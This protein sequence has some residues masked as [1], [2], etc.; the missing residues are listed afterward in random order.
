MRSA[1]L[2]GEPS[3]NSEDPRA[4]TA[5]TLGSSARPRSCPGDRATSPTITDRLFSP[6][7]R[8]ALLL[9]AGQLEREMVG[10]AL[11]ADGVEVPP[12]PLPALCRLPAPSEVHGQGGVLEGRQGRPSTW[13]RSFMNGKSGW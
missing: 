7:D 1:G 8:H 6:G 11:K 12:G 10:L 4:S 13:P 9:A 5:V 3:C 2:T